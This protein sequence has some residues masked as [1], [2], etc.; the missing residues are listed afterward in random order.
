MGS[1]LLSLLGRLLNRLGH[2]LTRWGYRLEMRAYFRSVRVKAQ[3]PLRKGELVTMDGR[4][5]DG[6][7]DWGAK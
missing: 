6:N 5:A 4:K 2:R 3:E 7:V 1:A